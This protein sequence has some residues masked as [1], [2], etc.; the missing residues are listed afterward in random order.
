MNSQIE[1]K[2]ARCQICPKFRSKQSKEPLINYNITDIPFY[3]TGVDLFHVNNQNYILI[4]DYYC[5]I[6]EI[7]EV[8]NLSSKAIIDALKQTFARYGIPKY[9]V[10]D[11]GPQF[12]SLEYKTFPSNYDFQ[13]NA[14]SKQWTSGKIPANHYKN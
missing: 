8:N 14:R 10:S 13:P 7:L 2:T 3:K 5:K 12:S 6:P 9:L 4:M 11:N 1:D